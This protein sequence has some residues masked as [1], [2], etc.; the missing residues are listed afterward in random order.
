MTWHDAVY[1]KCHF[2]DDKIYTYDDIKN[3][4]IWKWVNTVKEDKHARI[5]YGNASQKFMTTSGMNYQTKFHNLS[6]NESYH[7]A[8]I[9]S[10]R[11]A[12]EFQKT[13][14]SKE[15]TPTICK[16][17]KKKRNEKMWFPTKQI[18]DDFWLTIAD[19]VKK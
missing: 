8:R 17:I 13:T 18:C 6:K 12:F 14:N 4:N 10:P 3:L 7:R 2:S 1:E 15:T 5:K 11:L 16:V 19:T 9:S